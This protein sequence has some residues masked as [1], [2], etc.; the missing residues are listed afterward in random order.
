MSHAQIRASPDL[1]RLVN[2]GYEVSVRG[3]YLVVD[4]IPYVTPNRE[5]ARGALV[6]EL[7]LNGDRAERPTTHV[8]M[9][10]GE[11]H[12]CNA[13]GKPIEGI[14]HGSRNVMID[15]RLVAK[16]SFSN[17]PQGGYAD[18]FEKF[19]TY[20]TILSGPAASLDP[21]ATPKTF[22]PTEAPEESPFHYLET[23]SARAGIAEATMKLEGHRLAIVGLG[24]SGAYALDLIAKTPVREIHLFD[25][26]RFFTH[27]A[28]RAPGAASV[29]TLR[30]GPLKVDYLHAIYSRMHRGI[31]PHGI[32]LDESNVGE[33]AGMDFVFLCIDDGAAK[34]PIV[35][36]L[37][38]QGIPFVDV[39]M[40]LELDGQGRLGGVLRTTTSTPAKRGHFRRRVPLDP[41]VEDD[42]YRSNI[43]IAELNAMHAAFA[44]MRWKKFIG[45]YRDLEGEHSTTYTI[46]VNSLASEETE[47][48]E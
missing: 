5:V 32:A 36:Y 2:E 16:H 3:G 6:S 17:K 34:A 45:F 40:G 33:L 48:E 14:R 11:H 41:P 8:M 10:T 21:D 29:E 15:G 7:T 27:N 20:A 30:E 26:D 19:H 12:P 18:Y 38:D 37:E 13:N 35:A 44:V 31:V 23:A 39:G 25:G 42:A 28:F 22:R 9:F 47:D 1:Q 24:G 4:S 43:Q 46:D